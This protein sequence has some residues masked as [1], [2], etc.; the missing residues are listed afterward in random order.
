MAIHVAITRQVIPGCE[1]AFEESLR[2][3]FQESLGYK[4]VLGV[5]LLSPSPGSHSRE[6][7]ILRT[8]SNERE[9][10]AFYRSELFAKWQKYVAQLTE[11]PRTAREV[12]GLEAWFRTPE[13]PPKWK[14]AFLTWLGVWPT[15][16][17][18][19]RFLVPRLSGL[20]QLF[21]SA[22]ATAVVV[23]CLTWL[24]MPLLVRLFS[25]WLHLK[26]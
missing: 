9:R 22:I 21:G 15:I 10:D 11:G 23:A 19:S 26:T 17:I 13:S 12:H 24:V 5:H 25:L 2:E 18:V 8:F 16:W 7:G 4:G 20:P 1:Q 6:Y 3:L 14:M